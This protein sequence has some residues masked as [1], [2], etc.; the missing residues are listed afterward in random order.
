MY[1]M[2]DDEH[3][4]S[5]AITESIRRGIRDVAEGR[6]LPAAEAIEAMRAS[7]APMLARSAA[8]VPLFRPVGLRELELIAASGWRE[9]PP[10]L[11]GQPIFYP[12]LTHD[13]ARRIIDAW[14]SR[15]ADAGFCGFVTRFKVDRPVFDRYPVRTVGGRDLQELWVPAEELPAFN[16]AI[17]EGIHVIE[18]IYGRDFVG[19]ID[20]TT[21][22]PTHLAAGA[23]PA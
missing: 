7:L 4:E 23:P 13:Y 5:D 20:P 17:Y 1:V 3:A 21:R 22:M 19:A 11:V 9:F 2:N 6:V 14:N 18:S 15:E 8:A 16:A 12:V 10:R